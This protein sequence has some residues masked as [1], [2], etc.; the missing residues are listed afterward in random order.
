[1]RGADSLIN[2]TQKQS[3][4]IALLIHRAVEIATNTPKFDLSVKEIFVTLGIYFNVGW[5]AFWIFLVYLGFRYPD[6][7]GK[8]ALQ[9]FQGN[10]DRGD[11]EDGPKFLIF[12]GSAT[13]FWLFTTTALFGI[14]LEIP[15]LWAILASESGLF[16][17]LIGLKKLT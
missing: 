17:V 14:G 10:N 1:M 11:H 12:I 13:S 4:S 16:L 7:V 15:N 9:V 8:F 5:A 2:Y 6:V 3:D